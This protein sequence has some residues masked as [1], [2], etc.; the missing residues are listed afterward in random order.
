MNTNAPE[1]G[2]SDSIV[3]K[4]RHIFSNYPTLEKGIIYGSRAKGTYHS[5]S[6]IDLTLSGEHL[7]HDSLYRIDE[8]L[9]KLL[10]PYTFDLSL[11]KDIDN[12]NLLD[13]IQ[14]VGIVFYEKPSLNLSSLN[15]A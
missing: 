6:D 7:T 8:D 11:L 13:H 9:E 5:G 3:K 10:L 12:P 4:I 15:N 14:R 1:F 2:L